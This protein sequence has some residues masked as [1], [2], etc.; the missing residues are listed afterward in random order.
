MQGNFLYS[1]PVRLHFGEN[2]IDALAGELAKFGPKVLLTYGGGS[3]KKNGVYE[4][5]LAAL[6]KAGK[7]VVELPG[8]MPNPTVAKLNEGCKLAKAEAVDL[9]LAVGGGSTCD[10]AKALS[11]SAYCEEDPLDQVLS[12]YG[13]CGQQ[14]YSCWLR[15]DYGWDGVRDSARFC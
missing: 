8:V 11:V 9:I 10:Y 6:K 14:D 13:G 4:D 12:A 2:A 3:I 15:A 1:N 5:V 7:V